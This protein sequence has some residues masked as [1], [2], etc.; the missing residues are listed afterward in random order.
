MR[1]MKSLKPIDFVVRGAFLAAVV[2]GGLAD[3]RGKPETA[4]A[5]VAAPVVL[6]SPA[7]HLSRY[8]ARRLG[9]ALAG[10]AHLSPARQAQAECAEF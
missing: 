4:E 5:L 10:A 8:D 7:C 9:F 6:A 3:A 2:A 1:T